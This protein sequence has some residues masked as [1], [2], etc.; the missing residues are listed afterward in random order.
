M[1]ARVRVIGC[2][3]PDA[4][5]DALGLLAVRRVGER[6]GS[7]AGVE[8]V[9]AGMA[10]RVIDLLED[11]SAAVIV[12]AVRT[13]DG[14]REPGTLVRVQVGAKEMPR[15]VER[16]LSSHGLGLG[17]SLGMAAVLGRTP[18]VVFL[19]LEVGNVE[20]GQPLSHEVHAALPGLAVVIENEVARLLNERA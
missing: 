2:G 9:E 16:A 20:M 6:L 10:H 11:I 12:D 18:R 4:G 7:K 8:C 14:S 3:N 15:E 19:G 1:G 17:D 13:P 5:D